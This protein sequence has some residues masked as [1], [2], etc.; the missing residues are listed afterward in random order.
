MQ[1]DPNLRSEEVRNLIPA[2]LKKV[3]ET[4]LSDTGVVERMK[5]RHEKN[6]KREG[7]VPGKFI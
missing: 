5:L 4:A 2:A 1:D 6:M 3:L 7:Y